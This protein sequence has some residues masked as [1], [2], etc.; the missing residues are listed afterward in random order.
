LSTARHGALAARTF[1]RILLVKPSSLGDVIHALPVAYALRRRYPAAQIDWLVGRAFAPIL[2]GNPDIDEIV[3]FDRRRFS[4]L[5]M[6]AGPTRDFLRLIARLRRSAYEMVIDLQ[7]LFRSGFLAWSTGAPVRLGFPEAREGAAV[8]YTHRIPAGDPDSHAVDRNMRVG[9]LL[10]FDP[11]DVRFPL[12]L[13]PELRAEVRAMVGRAYPAEVPLV[14]VAPGA[15]WETK[16]WPPES[17]A[18]AIDAMGDQGATACVLLGGPDDVE[19]CDRIARQCRSRPLVLAGKT[20]LRQMAA[21]IEQSAVLLCHDSAPLH[22][23]AA[24]GRPLVCL[25]GP[26]NPARTGPYRRPADVTRL[27]LPCSPCY[28]RKL[29]QC[30]HRHECMTQLR[31]EDVVTEVLQRLRRS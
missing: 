25:A 8:F 16:R 27:P 30:P 18:R 15:R 12:Q 2:E 24:L 31:V 4:R 29:S 9:T 17:F 7:G 26:T 14:A 20:S 11:G 3:P 19:L 13:G 21:L 23:A 10:G 22:V 28:F 5:A 1:A 6:R